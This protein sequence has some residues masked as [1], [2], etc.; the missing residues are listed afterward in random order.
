MV[1]SLYNFMLNIVQHLRYEVLA[2]G[3]ASVVTGKFGPLRGT[4]HDFGPATVDKIIPTSD[5]VYFLTG[6]Y[7]PVTYND[8]SGTSFRNVVYFKYT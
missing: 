3:C 6:L 8:W 7:P 5:R 2:G 4:S 1:R